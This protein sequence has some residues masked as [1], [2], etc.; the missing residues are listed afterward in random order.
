MRILIKDLNDVLKRIKI[1]K[2]EYTTNQENIK[3]Q[4]KNLFQSWINGKSDNLEVLV[5][6]SRKNSMKIS[7][8]LN[9]LINALEKTTDKYKELG[10]EINCNLNKKEYTLSKYDNLIYTLKN[11]LSK[12]RRL[13]NIDFYPSRHKI[14]DNQNDIKKEIDKMEDL[15]GTTKQTFDY[16]LKTEK[17][18]EEELKDIS[19]PK[20]SENVNF[21]QG[22]SKNRDAYYFEYSE[23]ENIHKKIISFTNE[24]K[25]ILDNIK[26][27]LYEI[28]KYYDSTNIKK[29]NE[30]IKEISIALENNYKNYK[31]Y[32]EFIEMNSNDYE[33]LKAVNK[34]IM[35]DM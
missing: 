14:Y 12:Y 7:T 10:N 3:F 29:I 30:L 19:V 2:D 16:I 13:G 26:D 32:N 35:E 31:M 11:T 17:E 9:D 20:I 22:A 25:I 27:Y 8:S 21:N 15:K 18:L 33:R 4:Y 24:Q 28:E 34:N 6:T 23:I 1:Q 5:E